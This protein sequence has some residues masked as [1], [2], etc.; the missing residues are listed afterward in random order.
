MIFI[1]FCLTSLSVTISRSI[2]FA[3]DEIILFFFFWMSNIPLYVWYVCIPQTIK[4]H[5]I[6]F[7]GRSASLPCMTTFLSLFFSYDSKKNYTLPVHDLFPIYDLMAPHLC[8]S[9]CFII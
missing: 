9:L 4:K 7:L 8:F 2:H 3:A 1:F 6:L 5:F